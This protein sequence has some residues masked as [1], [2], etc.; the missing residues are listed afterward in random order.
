MAREV[1]KRDG[2]REPFNEDKIKAAIGAAA[3]MAGF[4]EEKKNELME[5]A[6]RAAIEFA[7]TKE[8]IAT[9]EIEAKV[10]SELD[11]LEPSVSAAWRRYRE[12]KKK[13]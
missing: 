11:R 13:A 9:T 10:L 5:Q 3:R 7:N 8:V 1:I 12:E 6:S 4:S 2:T